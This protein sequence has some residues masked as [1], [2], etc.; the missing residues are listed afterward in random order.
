MISINTHDYDFVVY[1]VKPLFEDRANHK[2]AVW[3]YMFVFDGANVETN[4]RYESEKGAKLAGIRILTNMIRGRYKE[5]PDLAIVAA[6][7][8]LINEYYNAV[9]DVQPKELFSK[10]RQI[11]EKVINAYLD[12]IDIKAF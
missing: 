10:N 2:W 11:L 3:K 7:S 5:N 1:K 4:K 6:E 9:G 12:E 8:V